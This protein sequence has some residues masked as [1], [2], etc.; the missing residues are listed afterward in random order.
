MLQPLA[1]VTLW[2]VATGAGGVAWAQGSIHGGPRPLTTAV[3]PAPPHG[4]GGPMAPAPEWRPRG[5]KPERLGR[6][7]RPNKGDKADREK[8]RQEILDQFRAMRMW[9]L[10][11]ELK[12]DEPTAARLFPLLSRYDDL[13]RDLGKERGQTMRTLR[14]L[15]AMPTPDTP[16][17]EALVDKLTSLRARR[18]TLE[19]EK[20]AAL[21]RVLSPVQMAKMLMLAPRIDEGFRRRIH[22][23]MGKDDAA[24]APLGAPAPSH[25]RAPAPPVRTPR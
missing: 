2:V 5:F 14:E 10:T 6:D 16:Q 3:P 13:E 9:T 1:A 22:E 11:E 25:P 8:L 15:L 20:T 17:I 7:D 23:A 21:R 4:G 19:A 24:G 12:L 18:H